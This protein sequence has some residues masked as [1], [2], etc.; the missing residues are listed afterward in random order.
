MSKKAILVVSFGTSVEETRKKTIDAIEADIGAAF[1]EYKVYSA[2]TSRR[3]AAKTGH[4]LIPEAM[5]TMIADGVKEL[6][7]Q[8]THIMKAVEYEGL[9]SDIKEYEGKFDLLKVGEPLVA[10][11]NGVDR[12]ARFLN[13]VY[14]KDVGIGED[15]IL[16]FMGHGTDHKENYIYTEIAGRLALID[17]K[18]TDIFIATVEGKP[19]IYDVIKSIDGGVPEDTTFILAPLMI[20]SGVHARD[21]LMGDDENSWKSILTSKGYKVRANLKGLGE[22][23]EIRESFAESIRKLI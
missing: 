12:M 21:D 8:P 9:L 4:P 3:I 15:E 11:D 19:N 22:Y 23:K 6:I 10:D 18:C 13:T 1:P 17:Y 16:L 5:E 7:V 20:V 14:R 2:W